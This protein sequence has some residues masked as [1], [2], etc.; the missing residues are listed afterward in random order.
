[1]SLP[2]TIIIYHDKPYARA[3]WEPHGQ[4]GWYLGTEM[5]HYHL[6]QFYID[7]ARATQIND[8]VEFFLHK[9]PMPCISSADAATQAARDLIHSL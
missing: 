1:M 6:H 3:S 5:E 4:P 7:K 8:I 9:F 2:G